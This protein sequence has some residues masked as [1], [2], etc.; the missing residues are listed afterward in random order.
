MKPL[1]VYKIL[2]AIAL[3]ADQEK[4]D[5]TYNLTLDMMDQ[6]WKHMSNADRQ[7]ADAWIASFKA[8]PDGSGSIEFNIKFD[9]PENK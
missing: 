1:D 5:T 2:T 8:Q 9:T 3:M 6:V 7:E 4:A